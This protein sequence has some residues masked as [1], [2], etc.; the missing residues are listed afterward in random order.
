MWAVLRCSESACF[1]NMYILLVF[2][3]GL[4][5]CYTVFM[6]PV[7]LNCELLFRLFFFVYGSGVCSMI[8]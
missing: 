3:S 5:D 7:N 1:A 8:N 4:Y 2:G 6:L